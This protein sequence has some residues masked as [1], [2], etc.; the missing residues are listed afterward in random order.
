V[1]PRWSSP[2]S[3]DAA[4]RFASQQSSVRLYPGETLL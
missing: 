3:R 2:R 1:S 4:G